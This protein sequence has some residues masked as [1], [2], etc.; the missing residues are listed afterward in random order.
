[1][2]RFF[3]PISQDLPLASR[4]FHIAQEVEF[5]WTKHGLGLCLVL[6]RSQQTEYLALCPSGDIGSPL[7]SSP[8]QCLGIYVMRT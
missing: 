8:S 6:P 4:S 5:Y 2:L 3:L 7:P 1:M